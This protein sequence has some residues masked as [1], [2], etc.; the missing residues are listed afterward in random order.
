MVKA[1]QRILKTAREVETAIPEEIV[2]DWDDTS[3]VRNIEEMRDS[4]AAEPRD[5]TSSW[6]PVQIRAGLRVLGP[7][8]DNWSGTASSDGRGNLSLRAHD[9]KEMSIQRKDMA[10]LIR[11]LRIAA[12][13]LTITAFDGTEMGIR[14]ADRP[15]LI[16]RLEQEAERFS[17]GRQF[18]LHPEDPEAPK[19]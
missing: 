16:D 17:T 10:D 5:V 7:T 4:L 19:K 9:G 1:T 15:A 13:D 11:V 18:P 12:G 2:P 6:K 14:D 3:V 8:G